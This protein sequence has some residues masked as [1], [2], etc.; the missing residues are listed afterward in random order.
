MFNLFRTI[1]YVFVLA[2][3]VSLTLNSLT[4][5]IVKPI[6]TSPVTSMWDSNGKAVGQDSHDNKVAWL[7]LAVVIILLAAA[8]VLANKAKAIEVGL[9]A[10]IPFS[11][12]GSS[13]LTIFTAYAQNA[14]PQTSALVITYGLAT[15]G[16][17][18]IGWW[19]FR[20]PEGQNG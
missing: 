1:I 19:K 3:V 5:V 2:A 8:G 16:V 11:L 13:P 17:L 18:A 15:L 10:T 20:N 9:I 6:D 14:N 4:P 12:T 7:R